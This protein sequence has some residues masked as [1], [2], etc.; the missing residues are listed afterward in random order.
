MSEC[1]KAIGRH[2]TLESM[3]VKE[4]RALCWRMGLDTSTCT[5]KR[6]MVDLIKRI[7]RATGAADEATTAGSDASA[8]GEQH[9]NAAENGDA[10]K[11]ATMLSMHGDESERNYRALMGSRPCLEH[12]CRRKARSHSSTTRTCMA[13]PPSS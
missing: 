9:L 11:V 13:S 10:S 8:A 6:D 1:E 12:C 2:A 3:S 4:L 7:P 5:D